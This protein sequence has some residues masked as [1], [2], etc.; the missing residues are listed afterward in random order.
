[1][2][3]QKDKTSKVAFFVSSL[4][5]LSCK[6]SIVPALRSSGKDQMHPAFKQ[7]SAQ[8]EISRQLLKD[9]WDQ[10]DRVKN[11]LMYG[12]SLKTL[13][14]GTLADCLLRFVRKE[15]TMIISHKY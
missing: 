5:L 9:N 2:E 15:E 3:E 11:Q 10:L 1:M 7:I 4:I 8:G 13:G 12:R 14:M 6:Y